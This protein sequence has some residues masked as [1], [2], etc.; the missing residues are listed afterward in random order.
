MTA[1]MGTRIDR[2][3]TSRSRKLRR[4]HHSDEQG[5]AILQLRRNVVEARGD[6]ADMYLHVSTRERPGNDGVAQ[7]VDEIDGC[8]VL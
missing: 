1:L 4:E 2:N 6:P 8:L 3:T 5:Q 7:V